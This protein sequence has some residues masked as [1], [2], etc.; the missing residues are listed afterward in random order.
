[1]HLATK[2]ARE[3]ARRMGGVKKPHCYRPGAVA[4]CEIHKSKKSIELLIGMAPFQRLDREIAIGFK[5]DL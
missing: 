1:M 3:K 2:A 4:L 5:S